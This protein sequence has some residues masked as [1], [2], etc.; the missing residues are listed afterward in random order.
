MP[1][2]KLV[3]EKWGVFQKLKNTIGTYP[4][5]E[6]LIQVILLVNISLPMCIPAPS[7]CVVHLPHLDPKPQISWSHYTNLKKK[8]G[9]DQRC[10]FCP[11]LVVCPSVCV[12]CR[13]GL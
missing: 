7:L 10:V 2:I 11:V 1:Y 4:E 5:S 12:Q 13:R 6:E 8:F 3:T 9:S